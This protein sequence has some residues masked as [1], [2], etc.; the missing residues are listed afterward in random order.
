M[1]KLLVLVFSCVV[2]IAA[3]TNVFAATIE[4]T[5]SGTL[6]VKINGEATVYADKLVTWHFSADTDDRYH[7]EGDFGIPSMWRIDDIQGTVTISGLLDTPTGLSQSYDIGSD[8]NGAGSVALTLHNDPDPDPDP[9]PIPIIWLTND[10]MAGYD[11][12]SEIGPFLC[13]IN[14]APKPGPYS[15]ESG[16]SFEVWSDENEKIQ[17]SFAATVVPIPSSILLL[18]AGL[19]ALAGFR[20]KLR[21]V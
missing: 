10:G 3:S 1:K 8:I 5:I 4:L 12:S 19:A 17:I 13:S 7:I 21:K 20:K 9:N 11:L 15:L 18:G 6:D 16:G 2:L 14:G